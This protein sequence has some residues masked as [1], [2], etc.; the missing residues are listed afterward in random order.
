MHRWLF[1]GRSSIAFVRFSQGSATA[2]Y[3]DLERTWGCPLLFARSGVR[4]GE[5]DR[6]AGASV[7]DARKL[8][9]PGCPR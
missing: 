5:E 1:L 3:K 8:A 7:S 9:A 4:A 6:A 2:C